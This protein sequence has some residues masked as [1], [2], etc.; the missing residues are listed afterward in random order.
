MKLFGTD[1]IRGEANQYPMT[2]EVALRVGMAVGY[3]FRNQGRHRRII[4]GKDTRLSGYMLEMALASGV[5]SM[6]AEAWLVGPLPTPAVA[7]LTRDLRA[8]AGVM[9]SAS[10]NPFYDNGIKIFAADGF[11]LPDEQEE[12]IE[13]LLNSSV[14]DQARSR[15]EGIGRAYRIEDA[16]GRYMVYLKR[17]FPEKMDLEGMRIVVDCAHGAT[18]RVA[19]EILEELG[20]RVI[21]LGCSPD[22]LN[23]NQECGALYPQALQKKVLEEGAEVGL[24]FDGDGDRL[25]MVDEKGRILDGDH[26]LA[27]LARDLKQRGELWGNAVAVT[28]MSNLG[29]ERFLKAEGIEVIRTQVGDRYVVEKMRE[30]GLRLGGEQ[31]GHIVFLDQS[32]TGDGILTALRVLAVMRQKEEPASEILNLFDRVPQVI[33][34]VRV[35]EKR[36]PEE[37]EGFSERMRRAR[38]ILGDKGRV[39]VRPSGTEPKYRVM[40][41]GEDQQLI[42]TLADELASY[43][44]KCLG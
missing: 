40:V 23:I 8:E 13:E 18:Y 10:H 42:E 43:L 22:G 38:E 11:K 24:A 3:L 12:R 29:L 31:S 2:P 9:I 27:Y 4:I 36:P 35:R 37:I 21:R 44:E 14:L 1:G 41:E 32:T 26:L 19:P 5:L 20:A 25:V 17:A 33:R 6:G 16:R 15:G 39:L 30:E 34:S 28:V 7:F